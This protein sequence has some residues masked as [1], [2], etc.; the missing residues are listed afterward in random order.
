MNKIIFADYDS[1]IDNDGVVIFTVLLNNF[2]THPLSVEINE[3]DNKIVFKKGIFELVFLDVGVDIK[4]AV[5][6]GGFDLFELDTSL[7]I[8]NHHRFGNFHQLLKSGMS[9]DYKW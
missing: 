3:I 9:G 8:V 6:S 2:Y 1:K 5:V 4:N 7:N